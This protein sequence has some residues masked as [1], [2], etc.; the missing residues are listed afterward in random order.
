MSKLLKSKLFVFG[1]MVLALVVL[2]G[3]ANAAYMHTVT[4]K[5]GMSGSQVLSLQ[6][7][8]GVTPSTG[9]FGSLTKAAVMSYQAANGLVADGVVGPMTG[10]KLSAGYTP[11]YTPPSSGNLPAGCT[12]TSGYS[13]VSGVKCDSMSSGNLPA[14]CMPGYMYSVT[15]G[16]KCDGSSTPSTPSTGLE[17]GAGSADYTLMSSLSN[18]QV[19]E[20]EEDVEVAGLEIEANGSDLKLT[21][22]RLVFDEG[23][24]GSDFEDYATEVSVWLDGKEI[25]RV[26]ANEFNDDNNWIATVTLDGGVIKEGD[27][28]ELTVAVSGISNLDTN[29]A[30]DSW[31]VDFRSVR[32]EDAQGASTSEDP[33]TA[34]RTFTFQNFATATDAELKISE[35]SDDE[36][37]NVGH[38]LDGAASTTTDD[39]AIL[40]FTLEADGDSDLKI[41][42]FPVFLT[43]TVES[44]IDD[45]IAGG[46]TP[47]I[48]LE[49][50]G[51][52][53]GTAT[54]GGA[55]D[56]S[57]TEDTD[58]DVGTTEAVLFD[59]VDFTLKAGDK[60]EGRIL[61]DLLAVDG[62][63]LTAG[64]T[65]MAQIREE[66]TDEVTFTKVKDESG[67][68]LA[69]GDLTGTVSADAME[70]RDVGFVFK[71]V[72]TSAAVTTT[73]DA[74][75]TTPTSDIGTFTQ[76]FD[77]T[78]FGGAIAIDKTCAED[79][80]QG[81]NG[82]GASVIVTT[83]GSNTA[84]CSIASSNA[85]SSST[86]ANSWVVPDGQTKR[87]TITTAV[88]STADHFAKTYLEA[89]NWDV[90]ANAAADT[91]FYTSGLGIDNTS[92]S[93]IFLND[94]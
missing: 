30:N 18:E 58:G 85:S 70:V 74:A 49:L 89:I 1:V 77:V 9:Y 83:A 16:Q 8:L 43:A 92:T 46:A 41:Q 65:I 27:T 33:S 23:T 36:D 76:T 79:E 44:H 3:T 10:A 81:D 60:V 34:T 4:L 29:D 24:A 7:T 5:Q 59:D 39:V 40:N 13:P 28:G 56:T 48:Y 35:S 47:A 53:Y 14:G 52:K 80:D 32:Y 25:G 87:F 82:E 55:G 37:A 17:G 71:L 57:Y 84:T 94:N 64:A 19:G 93:E 38:M 62:S 54:Y 66:E 6:Q 72:S 21:A 78:A 68:S 69:D 42:K 31:T 88:T 20:D 2:A 51:D 75:A 11:T 45:I 15:T 91:L 22:V 26:D 50:D 67:T 90:D 12:S 63:P 86:S 61:V 73:G